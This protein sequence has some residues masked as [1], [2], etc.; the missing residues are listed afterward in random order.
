MLQVHLLFGVLVSSAL[1]ESRGKAFTIATISLLLAG[2]EL[3]LV[4]LTLITFLG[5]RFDSSCSLRA[6]TASLLRVELLIPELLTVEIHDGLKLLGT[7]VD[8]VTDLIG[9]K[10]CILV[11]PPLDGLVFLEWTH[12]NLLILLTVS[13]HVLVICAKDVFELVLHL[14]LV[15]VLEVKSHEQIFGYFDHPLAQVVDLSPHPADEERLQLYLLD[16]IGLRVNHFEVL[17]ERLCA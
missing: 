10:M 13:S 5:L 2:F 17:K 16:L 4:L 6:A 1:L 12:L 8:L 7:F 3:I 14:F 15:H 9:V 11:N